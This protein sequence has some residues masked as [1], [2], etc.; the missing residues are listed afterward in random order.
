V[1]V[2]TLGETELGRQRGQSGGGDDVGRD[3]VSGSAPFDAGGHLV[4]ARR[5]ADLSQRELAAAAGVP[6]SSLAAYESGRRRV[7]TDALARLLREAGLR[8]AVV[9][10]Q[11]HEVGPVAAD[12]VRDNGARR[13][14]AHL[15]VQP[16]DQ[17]PP[18]VIASPRYDRE[19]AKAWYHRRAERDRLRASGRAAGD[20]PTDAELEYRRLATRYGRSPWWPS[21]SA[22]LARA[23]GDEAE[24]LPGPAD[25][26][27]RR[28]PEAGAGGD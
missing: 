12:A 7:S 6:Q 11:G 9:D 23:L 16:P 19:P 18:G 8:L 28:D 24:R 26:A 22:G 21:R 5:L 3:D 2:A 13:F 17:L 4:R 27:P 15:D 14:P 20:H 1:V 25:R 10:A